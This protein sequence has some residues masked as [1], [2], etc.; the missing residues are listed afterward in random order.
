M[1]QKNKFTRKNVNSNISKKDLPDL[2]ME[3]YEKELRAVLSPIEISKL[4]KTLLDIF[5]KDG[6]GQ[7]HL[8]MSFVLEHIR[9]FNTH[10]KE[11]EFEL[12]LVNKIFNHLSEEGKKF[13]DINAQLLLAN[14]IKLNNISEQNNEII[15]LLKEIKNK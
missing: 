12:D 2:L 5:N 9:T 4:R 7:V 8:Y 6:E 14:L 3:N 15:N 11:I 13:R 10:E 1:V